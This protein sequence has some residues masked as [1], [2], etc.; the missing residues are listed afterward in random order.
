MW[1]IKIDNFFGS[2]IIFTKKLV[3]KF[4][5]VS[6]WFNN[7]KMCQLQIKMRVSVY[8]IISLFPFLSFLFLFRSCFVSGFSFYLVLVAEFGFW[9]LVAFFFIL[10]PC[11]WSWILD[12]S[13]RSRILDSSDRFWVLDVS[14]RF[15]V[16]ETSGRFC[17]WTLI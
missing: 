17:F 16:L 5:Y 2:F 11:G 10:D 14:G 3:R 4:S 9:T 1:K 7:C 12:P 6:F 15:F 13:G 8:L